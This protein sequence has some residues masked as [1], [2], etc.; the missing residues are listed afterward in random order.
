M[1]RTRTRTPQEI[2]RL[3]TGYEQS[4]LSRQ[5][6][7]E[8]EGIPVTTLDYYR[9][10]RRQGQ[11]IPA[12]EAKLVKV[13]L[14]SAQS[15]KQEVKGFILALAKGRRIESSWSYSEQDLARLIRIVEAV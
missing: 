12:L 1:A 7:C 3:L 8:R 4:G 6:Y 14:K 13:E 2:E 5:R 15:D 10:H 9:R 11:R